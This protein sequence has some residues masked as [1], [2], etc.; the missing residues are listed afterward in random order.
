MKLSYDLQKNI[1]YIT[2]KEGVT[3]VESVQIGADLAVDLAPDG[4]VV[5]IE[6]LNA[7][8]QLAS[9]RIPLRER[10]KRSGHGIAAPRL[11]TPL[12]LRPGG[13]AAAKGPPLVG[14][15]LDKERGHARD[16]DR[17]EVHHKL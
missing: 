9:R 1:A 10:S 3:E 15:A 14:P 13:T 4:T 16:H 2:L 5:G 12:P 7:G 11:T 8:D 6:F 17:S